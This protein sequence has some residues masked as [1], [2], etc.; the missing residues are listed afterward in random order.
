MHD[1]VGPSDE[2]WSYYYHYL[3][4]MCNKVKE[5]R[6]AYNFSNDESLLLNR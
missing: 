5:A 4:Y 6:K 2:E 1:E 3:L